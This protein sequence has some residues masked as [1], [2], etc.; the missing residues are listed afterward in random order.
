MANTSH[1]RHRGLRDEV[2]SRVLDGPGEVDAALRHAAAEGRGLPADLQR[3]V[4]KIEQHAYMVTD[5]D[6]MAL[7]A[8]YSDDALFELIVSA[9][10]GASRRRLAAGLAALEQASRQ[11]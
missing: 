1:D 11:P 4:D 8:T 9:A 7:Q 2:L 3:L 5:A 6:I 10:L